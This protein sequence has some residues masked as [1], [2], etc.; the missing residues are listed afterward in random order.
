MDHSADI[1]VNMASYRLDPNAGSQTSQC[2][3]RCGL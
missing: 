1:H 3:Y 2:R